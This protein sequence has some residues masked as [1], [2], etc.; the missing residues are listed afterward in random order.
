MLYDTARYYTI[1]DHTIQSY[2]YI[3][4]TRPNYTILYNTIPCHT[5]KNTFAKVF[6]Q[7]G[8]STVDKSMGFSNLLISCSAWNH[9][10]PLHLFPPR[11]PRH[12]TPFGV[13]AMYSRCDRLCPY[14]EYTPLTASMQLGGATDS[15]TS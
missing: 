13:Q 4:H 3:Y 6:M 15:T 10:L 9:S 2:I 11:C 8:T 1:L 12:S 14:V 7:K 5:R